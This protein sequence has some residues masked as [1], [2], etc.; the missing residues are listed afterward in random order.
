MTELGFADFVLD[1]GHV[2]IFQCLA[3]QA[4]FSEE[5][6]ETLRGMLDEKNAMEAGAFLQ[7]LG[8]LKEIQ[9][10]CLSLIELYG[11]VEVLDKAEEIFYQSCYQSVLKELRLLAVFLQQMGHGNSITIDLGLLPGFE[12]YNG[13]VFRGLGAGV[14][15][16]IISG[17]RYDGVIGSIWQADAGSGLCHQ[18]GAGH[19][20]A[21]SRQR[22][23]GR[24]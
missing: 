10:Q 8:V 3:K 7:Q 2:G 19:G 23:A 1:I 21:Q 14:G 9:H 11:G 13:L 4:G 17:G 18:Y 12:Y 5:E 6:T 22:L 20:G 16:P 15:S 24:S